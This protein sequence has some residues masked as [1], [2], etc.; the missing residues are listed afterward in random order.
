MIRAIKGYSST[1]WFF[2]WIFLQQKKTFYFGKIV[3][4]SN[5]EDNQ[6][7]LIIVL[8]CT[9]LWP[10]IIL[11]FKNYVHFKK[12]KEGYFHW[13]NEFNIFLFKIHRTFMNTITQR[14]EEIK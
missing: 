12:K 3:D 4:I 9:S 6:S 8:Y 7:Y 14:G 2:C 11:C 10:N 5:D 1:K 13:M